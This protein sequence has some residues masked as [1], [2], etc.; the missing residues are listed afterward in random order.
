MIY[1]PNLSR[2]F[3][4][5]EIFHWICFKR[6]SFSRNY[7]SKISN[8]FNYINVSRNIL[9]MI[10][11]KLNYW[12]KQ[13]NISLL[14]LSTPG[15]CTIRFC[16]IHILLVHLH[17]CPGTSSTR[18]RA[19]GTGAGGESRMRAWPCL[20]VS[21]HLELLPLHLYLA[22]PVRAEAPWHSH[23]AW[24]PR[25]TAWTTTPWRKGT[26][27]TPYTRVSGRSSCSA[28]RLEQGEKDFTDL[29]H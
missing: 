1:C 20:S 11:G 14:V 12:H 19:W 27:L 17:P 13:K 5:K 29:K 4:S 9:E 10:P 21:E 2:Y 18:L 24:C 23:S 22:A 7:W 26:R 28:C 15:H 8:K 16:L 25:H 3:N 6:F